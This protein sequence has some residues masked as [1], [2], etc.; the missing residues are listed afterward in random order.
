[1]SKES[2]KEM[3]KAISYVTEFHEN[4]KRINMP[5]DSCYNA[6]SPKSDSSLA[7]ILFGF[8][9]YNIHYSKDQES[10]TSKKRIYTNRPITVEDIL[11]DYD[12]S[13]YTVEGKNIKNDTSN[14][15]K[16]I[17]KLD[18]GNIYYSWLCN[19]IY[20]FVM[21]REVSSWVYY[22]KDAY[23]LPKTIKKIISHSKGMINHMIS[24]HRAKKENIN[25][26][27]IEISFGKF[28]QGIINRM[29]PDIVKKIPK[30]HEDIHILEYLKEV[31]II[32]KGI[33]DLDGMRISG[34]F[35]RRLPPKFLYHVRKYLPGGDKMKSSKDIMK[36]LVPKDSSLVKKKRKKKVDKEPVEKVEVIKEN[37][38]AVEEKEVKTLRY[39]GAL[40]P[41]KDSPELVKYFRA[42]LT[43]Y[44]E[45]HV[46]FG[47]FQVDTPYAA[48]AL[49]E[50]KISK[51][52]SKEFLDEWLKYF[53]DN[54]L[55]GRMSKV[56]SL[57]M[58][59]KTFKNFNE[60]FYMPK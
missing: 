33:E 20:M 54:K 47:D 7:N 14:M 4:Y 16:Q 23:V 56:A 39:V 35:F 5:L 52:E 1:M 32:M 31:S 49:D 57:E 17:I 59:E 53:F 3:Y 8:T 19:G 11:Y 60:T 34:D 58:F 12:P 9:L 21:E 25:V 22:N 37:Q 28:I 6:I 36:E 46:K 30:W 43:I 15:Q 27:Y 24:F 10:Y 29:N 45:G 50:M 40:D 38:E 51:R 2:E 42:F 13:K 26:I 18:K 44:S 48:K 41:L 55:K